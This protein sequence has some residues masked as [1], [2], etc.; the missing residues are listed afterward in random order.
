MDQLEQMNVI[1]DTGFTFIVLFVM[2]SM[3]RIE[4]PDR[5]RHIS[6]PLVIDAPP[7]PGR[8][9]EQWKIQTFWVTLLS[10]SLM[11]IILEAILYALWRH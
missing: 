5:V 6:L 4:F 11:L 8:E 2:V 9:R 10:V 7:P 3:L 1:M